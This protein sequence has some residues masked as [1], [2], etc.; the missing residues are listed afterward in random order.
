MSDLRIGNKLITAPIIDIVKQLQKELTNGKLQ[1]WVDKGDNIVVTCPSHKGGL[2]RHPSCAIYCGDSDEVEYG[3]VHCFTCGLSGPLW[4][5]V[6]E[7]FDQDDAFGK[8]W[9]SE[10]FGNVFVQ[11]SVNIP[12]I[13]LNAEKADIKILRESALDNYQSYHPYMTQRKL[14][15]EVIEKYKIKYDPQSGCIVFPVWDINDNLIFLTR[16]SVYTKQFIID[17]DVDKPVYLLN[18]AVKEKVKNL[19]IAE[20]QINALTLNGWGYPAV[21]LFGTGT[22]EQIELLNKSG[23]RCFT[24]CFD[25]DEAGD[26]GIERF[27]KNIRKDVIVNVIKIPRGLDVNDMN[28]EDFTNLVKTSF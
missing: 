8:E 23:I 21:A 3:T 1:A 7:C 11:T 2:E 6:A 10:R 16:R 20:S 25:G 14:T 5:F 4:H 28:K 9:L 22:K 26:K 15:A 18:F 27:L 24:L 13:V 17:K 19:F 12:P